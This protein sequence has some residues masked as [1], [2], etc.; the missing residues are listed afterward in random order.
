MLIFGASKSNF[1]EI[2]K[3]MLK[4][5]NAKNMLNYKMLNCTKRQSVT[6]KNHSI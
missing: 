2:A 6:L 5:L 3:N 1:L 4:N